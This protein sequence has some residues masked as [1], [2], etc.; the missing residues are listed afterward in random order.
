M[1]NNTSLKHWLKCT[2]LSPSPSEISRMSTCHLTL[3]QVKDLAADSVSDGR[4]LFALQRT[5]GK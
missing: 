4:H 5:L 3:Q 1:L 2:L